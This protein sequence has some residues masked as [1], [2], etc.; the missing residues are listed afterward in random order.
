VEAGRGCPFSCTFCSTATF[1]QRRY[2]LKSP[3]RLV[4]EMDRLADRYGP[5]ELKLDHDLFTVD[6]RR[7]RAF[8]D[9]VRGHGHRWRV[10]ARVDC[11]DDE[12][13]EDMAD[14]GCVGLYF[15]VETGSPRM[16]KVVA[17]R[18]DLA[19]V[20]PR[21]DT[22]A[23]LGIEATASFI[24]GYPEETH[25]DQ[26]ATLDM[27][28]RCLRRPGGT[29]LTQLHILTPEPGTP[30]FDRL[31][32]SLAFDGYA[33]PFNAWLLRSEDV[34][35]LHADPELFATYYHYPTAVPRSEHIGVVEA[36]DLLRRLDPTLLSVLV[37]RHPRG[38]PGL[39]RDLVTRASEA[40]D[41]PVPTLAHLETYARG[42]L[43]DEDPV[44][45]ALRYLR[46]TAEPPT[47]TP[48]PAPSPSAPAPSSGVPHPRYRLPPG[49]RILH[50]IHDM[51]G[52]AAW[53]AGAGTDVSATIPRASYVRLPGAVE[54]LA[55]DPGLGTLLELF[56][57]GRDVSNL[58][59]QLAPAVGDV[60]AERWLPLLLDRGLLVPEEDGSAMDAR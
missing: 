56:G 48:S 26:D 17:K 22:C 55:V 11:V 13:L 27:V 32:G 34:H 20:D 51:A 30:L 42:A 57:S 31:S 49:T 35:A 38:F 58:A 60:Q 7:V 15:G 33:T 5:H 1:F 36:V 16:Q 53:L 41:P 19:L 18:L 59:E 50:G 54:T 37:D 4:A 28:G 9:A 47:P 46:F 21:L 8:C 40:V 52:V 43:G 2:R 10:S 12:L 14:A 25:P 45:S 44:T 24:T 39:V 6:R 23:R 3:H 29:C